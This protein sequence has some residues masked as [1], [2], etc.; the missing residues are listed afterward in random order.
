M[1]AMSV[2]RFCLSFV[3]QANQL[4][5]RYGGPVYLVG[6]ALTC[7]T[8]SDFDVRV[9]ITQADADRL[10]GTDTTRTLEAVWSMQSWRMAYDALKQSRRSTRAYAGMATIDVQIQV[11]EQDCYKDKPRRRLDQAPAWLWRAGLEDA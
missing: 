2:D 3:G 6:S 1:L 8:P 4:A 9:I 5:A 7:E 11:G 10:Y